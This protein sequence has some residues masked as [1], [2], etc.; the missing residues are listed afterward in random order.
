MEIQATAAVSA[1]ATPFAEKQGTAERVRSD[2][3]A[4]IAV[5][6]PLGQRVHES[7]GVFGR[8]LE[9]IPFI[10]ARSRTR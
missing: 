2:F 8:R 9:Q 4:G 10:P 5:L 7:F 3:E 1:N 6:I